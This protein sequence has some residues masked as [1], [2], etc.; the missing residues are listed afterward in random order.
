MNKKRNFSNRSFNRYIIN[1]ESFLTTKLGQEKRI[2]L[3]DLSGKG[4][5]IVV[6]IPLKE[7]EKIMLHLNAPTFLDKPVSITA[8][9]TWIKKIDENLWRV[10]L[11]FGLG[12]LELPVL[13]LERGVVN[14]GFV[15]KDFK[16]LKIIFFVFLVCSA[17]LAGLFIKN[18]LRIVAL[19]G[20]SFDAEGKSRALINGE[21]F[22]ANEE[23]GDFIEIKWINED[24]VVLSMNGKLKILK[25]NE[26]MSYFSE[27]S[28]DFLNT[29]K[30]ALR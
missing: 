30:N 25:L 23:I 24:S 5:A 29:L 27:S 12:S 28:L 16:N 15:K 11:H 14:K 10:G 3:Q 17:V 22:S 20:I 4:A 8:E 2:L 13:N 6:D 9:V 19:Q 7:K 1:S 18:S 26:R 21:F